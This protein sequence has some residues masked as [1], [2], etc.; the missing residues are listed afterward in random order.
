MRI[1]CSHFILCFRV[2]LCLHWF[3]S[4][5]SI[6]CFCLVLFCTSLFFKSVSQSWSFCVWLPLCLWQRNFHIYSSFFSFECTW[7]LSF[8]ANSDLYLPSPFMFLLSQ[9]ISFYAMFLS[10]VFILLYF[11]VCAITV[12]PTSPR[13]SPSTHIPTPSG[14]PHTPVHAHGSCVDI[15]WL[16]YSQR[17]T[18][19]P[20]TIL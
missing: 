14:N 17:C 20:M 5:V 13:L 1:S 7:S 3:F 2:A 11:I 8:F 9:I 4:F 18:L 10:F 16:L 19:L 15:L 6:C 12:V